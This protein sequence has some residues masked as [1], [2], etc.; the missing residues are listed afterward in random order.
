M[1]TYKLNQ[2]DAVQYPSSYTSSS[3][4]G[5]SATQS[6]LSQSEAIDLWSHAILLFHNLEWEQAL[7]AHRRILRQC[8]TDV[9]RACLWFN[10][11]VIRGLLGEY[12]LAAEAFATA[13]KFEP[14]LTISW[15]CLGISLFQLNGF[16]KAKKAFDTCLRS[17]KIKDDINY[18]DQGL[19]FVLE[20]TKVDW[21]CRQASFEKNHQQRRAP[22]PL[23]RHMG[24]NRL[25]AGILF[26]P[27]SLGA[28]DQFDTD[29][30]PPQSPNPQLQSNTIDEKTASQYS[31]PGKLSFSPATWPRVSEPQPPLRFVTA[32][33]LSAASAT[34]RRSKESTTRPRTHSNP[35]TAGVRYLLPGTIVHHDGPIPSTEYIARTIRLDESV[36]PAPIP[37]VPARSSTSSQTYISDTPAITPLTTPQARARAHTRPQSHRTTPLPSPTSIYSQPF[38]PPT[39]P[40]PRPISIN[41]KNIGATR[42]WLDKTF[43]PDRWDSLPKHLRTSD[44]HR[45]RVTTRDRHSGQTESASSDYGSDITGGGVD[46][47]DDDDDEKGRG[48]DRDRVR[49]AEGDRESIASM[50]SFA[51]VGMGRRDWLNDLRKKGETGSMDEI[52]PQRQVKGT[53]NEKG[54][55]KGNDKGRGRRWA[56]L[57]AALEGLYNVR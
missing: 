21:N 2:I 52:L 4:K 36:H 12:F 48:R 34:F 54:R 31:Q 43:P 37:H 5:P 26:E 6:S 19:D 33:D 44:H 8:G 1:T 13:L 40:N 32:K 57:P 3:S 10:I 39:N 9:R 35:Q 50:D 23:E 47:D 51:I 56:V 46:D 27:P 30:A 15:Y 16:R 41:A 7:T 22:L 38:I 28:D 20:Q 29:T 14:H 45:N 24:L 18:H 25:P 49:N 42:S 17:F 55:G 53:G 11:G